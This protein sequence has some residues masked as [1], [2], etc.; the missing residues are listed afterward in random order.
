[1]LTWKETFYQN[2][3]WQVLVSH[4]VKMYRP[5]WVRSF[6]VNPSTATFYL[7]D[8]ASHIFSST[9]SFLRSKT[10]VTILL[11]DSF[12]VSKKWDNTLWKV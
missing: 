9:F 1:M 7:S 2:I 10:E 5:I 4:P 11:G 12:D 6:C 3:L 8:S